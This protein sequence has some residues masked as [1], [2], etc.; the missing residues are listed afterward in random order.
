[1][2]IGCQAGRKWRG[3]CIMLAMIKRIMKLS[4][5]NSV[6]LKKSFICGIIESFLKNGPMF[7]FLFVVIKI[8]ENTINETDIFIFLGLM[9]LILLLNVIVRQL[10][11]VYQST[12]G[13]NMMADER[14][15]LGN[16]I[17]RLPMG[18]FNDGTIGN[19]STVVTSDMAFLE[20]LAMDKLTLLFSSYINITMSSIIYLLLDLRIG[21]MVLAFVGCSVVIL[22]K[23]H[24]ESRTLSNER[25]VV[26]EGLVR[27]VIDYAKGMAITKSFN[28][29]GKRSKALNKSLHD[30]RD[31]MIKFEKRGTP[32][33]MKNE[34]ILG[35][36]IGV[37][38]F[39]SVLF[40]MQASLGVYIVLLFCVFVFAVFTPL[41]ALSRTIPMFR[42]VE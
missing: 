7:L 25:Q 23:V 4:G 31:I 33:L 42:I 41:M 37:I 2:G 13:Y 1:M 8:I 11:H 21:L 24:K 40:T 20:E 30:F 29:S 27:N 22:N 36:A 26:Q 35:A 18:Y 6:R 39:F 5:K 16:H 12:T 38:I 14:M 10:I 34:S 3:K 28:L 19:I 32:P 17:K 15:K 9:G